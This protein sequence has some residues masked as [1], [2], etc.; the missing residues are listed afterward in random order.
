[1]LVTE[2]YDKRFEEL[3][4]FAISETITKELNTTADEERKSRC[5]DEG[6]VS[7][8]ASLRYQLHFIFG[9]PFRDNDLTP[10][11]VIAGFEAKL[12]YDTEP[13]LQLT[14]G[15]HGYRVEHSNTDVAVP[16]VA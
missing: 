9:T 12:P 5:K 3:S 7:L 8:R 15:S 16:M 6:N 10:M 13:R 2:A 1:M 4:P 14:A 11:P